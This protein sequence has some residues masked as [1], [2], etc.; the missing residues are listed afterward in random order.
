MG[1]NSL[2]NTLFAAAAAFGFVGL[3]AARHTG[4]SVAH[5]G[6]VAGIPTDGTIADVAERTVDS[7]VNISSWHDEKGMVSFGDPFGGDDHRASRSLAK[8]SGV[9]GT[10]S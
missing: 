10:G 8:G 6:P 7:V 1:M 3:G 4:S 2:R 5:A 9:I